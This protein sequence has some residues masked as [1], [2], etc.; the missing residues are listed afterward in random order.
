MT[1]TRT[2]TKFA[3]RVCGAEIAL[4]LK[5]SETFISQSD[6]DDF[7]GMKLTTFRVYHDTDHERHYNSVIV[8]QMGFFRGHRDAYIEPLEK[9]DTVTESTPDYWV[10]HEDTPITKQLEHLQF[11]FLISR[12]HRW[13]VDIVSPKNLNATE[14]SYHVLNRLEEAACIYTEL[15]QPLKVQFADLDIYCWSSDTRVLCL[16]FI[17]GVMIEK[18]QSVAPL[19]VEESEDSIVPRSRILNLV[20][21]ILELDDEVSSSILEQILNADMLFAKFQ[22]PFEERIPSIVERTAR[23]FP[24]A[25]DILGPLL[26]GYTT[27]I[28][29][30]E[31]KYCS[32]Y[33]EVFELVD[34]V[35]RRNILG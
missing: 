22:T 34:F 18:F 6:H 14:M 15:P 29:V 13:V 30:L 26:R 17:D 9:L 27:L 12:K 28:E 1:L 4:D 33:K 19:I 32:R 5:D 7:F 23:R 25:K 20:F 2:V 3:C 16:S 24:I 35:N 31:D 10:Y 11:A 21:R 8:D